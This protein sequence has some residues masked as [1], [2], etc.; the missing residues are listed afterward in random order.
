MPRIDSNRTKPTMKII[1]LMNISVRP[2]RRD[3]WSWSRSACR[4]IPSPT[5]PG[6]MSAHAKAQVGQSPELFW[7]ASTSPSMVTMPPGTVATEP[8]PANPTTSSVRPGM[9]TKSGQ[10][11]WVRS[12]P[13]ITTT[14][15]KM[16]TTTSTRPSARLEPP[17][18]GGDV[19]GGGGGGRLLGY[20][21]GRF[22]LRNQRRAR[23]NRFRRGRVYISRLRRGGLG[24]GLSKDRFR[25]GLGRRWLLGRF[26]LLSGEDVRTS[27]QEVGRDVDHVVL[28]R[29]VVRRFVG[30]R[31]LPWGG[32]GL[33]GG[34]ALSLAHGTKSLTA[35]P[36]TH[37]GPE[38]R[39]HRPV[40]VADL[41]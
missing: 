32:G 6:T 11:Y 9:M 17:R 10:P 34:G 1:T 25:G 8:T 29:R 39:V 13:A 23:L 5:P 14:K 7:Y 24:W 15:A 40:T 20:E 4:Y 30:G 2:V 38:N 41:E 18:R 21:G 27:G 28:D 37:G 22:R 16:P 26:A 36:V 3:G 31:L 12:T 19:R 33:A 35:S